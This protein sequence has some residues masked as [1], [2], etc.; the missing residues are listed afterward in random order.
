MPDPDPIILQGLDGFW[1]NK[2][3]ETSKFGP[4]PY[5]QHASVVDLGGQEGVAHRRVYE[6]EPVG[7]WVGPWWT[8]FGPGPDL[9]HVLGLNDSS[10]IQ[11]KPRTR[12]YYH[13]RQGPYRDI[14]GGSIQYPGNFRSIDI[15]RRAAIN[16][17]HPPTGS[18]L[19]SV[20]N[21]VG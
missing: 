5:P 8:Q 2:P 12:P 7:F 17:M 20:L 6:C 19:S 21:V 15:P 9:F 16:G 10:L 1:I 18:G 4:D 3:S 11:T 13:S 14:F